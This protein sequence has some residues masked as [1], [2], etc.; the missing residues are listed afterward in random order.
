MS[1]EAP[2]TISHLA[3]PSTFYGSQVRQLCQWCGFR[4]IDQ[5]LS[6]VAYAICGEVVN[7]MDDGPVV[8]QL[9]PDHR[10]GHSTTPPPYPV[11]TGWVEVTGVNP[12]VYSSLEWDSEVAPENSCMRL[13]AMWADSL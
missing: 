3:G 7:E 11:W 6:L 13:P 8:C 10:D 12:K 4:I 2:A 9:G 5:D 1:D